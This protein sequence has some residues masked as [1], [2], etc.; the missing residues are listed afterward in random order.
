VAN[1]IVPI[2]I[3]LAERTLYLP[4][5]A[6]GF[7]IAALAAR[8]QPLEP[9]V[10]QLWLA[11]GVAVLVL[12]AVRTN[13]RIPDWDSTDKILLAQMRDRSDSFRAHWHVAR[14]ERRD[15]RVPR[16]LE[17]YARAV[18]LWPYRQRLIVE[19]AGYASAE[20][21]PRLAYRL[22]S[23]GAQR[24]PNNAQLQRLLAANAL[25]LGDTVTARRAMIEGL[26]L[27]PNDDLLK[28]MAATLGE[29]KSAR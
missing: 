1:L 21:Q 29:K 27:T 14:I 9:R 8:V 22:A 4:S 25:D 5:I 24:W 28:R 17:H 23:F 15:K 12:L 7:A 19:A 3:M 11:G 6:L 26:K 20:S 2:G 10:R 18:E 13:L 16:A